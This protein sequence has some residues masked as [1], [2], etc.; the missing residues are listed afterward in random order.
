LFY[1]DWN[2]DPVARLRGQQ[3]FAIFLR[4]DWSST[5]DKGEDFRTSDFYI[6]SRVS[7]HFVGTETAE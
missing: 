7:G 3:D 1:S 4:V 6:L 2:L 5:E